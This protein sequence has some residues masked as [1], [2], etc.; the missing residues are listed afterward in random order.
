MSVLSATFINLPAERVD[1][2]ITNGLQTLAETLG[3]DRSSI[4]FANANSGE[5]TITHVWTREG[6]PDYSKGLL[7]SIM[8]WLSRRIKMGE[9]LIANTPEDLPAEAR[10]EREFMES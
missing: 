1:T 7:H 2:E 5:I 3:G 4:G 8:P 10:L 6:F 9:T